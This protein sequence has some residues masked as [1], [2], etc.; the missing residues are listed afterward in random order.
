M[1]SSSSSDASTRPPETLAAALPLE[2]HE[3]LVPVAV[4]E[5]TGA[6]ALLVTDPIG[7]TV[8]RTALPAVASTLLMTIFASVDAY[9]I[10]TRI[11]AAG[12]AAATTSIF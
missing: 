10:G 4:R 7:R 2:P 6:A 9:W 5:D 1:R 3:G 11:G 12:I 8:L